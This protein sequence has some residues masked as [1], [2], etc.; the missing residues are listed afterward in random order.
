V[1]VIGNVSMIC[2]IIFLKTTNL[3]HVLFRAVT[4]GANGNFRKFSGPN[5]IINTGQNILSS[6]AGCKGSAATLTATPA[7]VAGVGL[8]LVVVADIRFGADVAPGVGDAGL[9]SVVG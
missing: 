2:R 3:Y 6:A 9:A 4:E 5:I 7:S 8:G 1:T